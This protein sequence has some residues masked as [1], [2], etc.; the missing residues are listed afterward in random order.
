MVHED[1]REWGVLHLKKSITHDAAD[2]DIFNLEYI[3]YAN[4]VLVLLTDIFSLI[5]MVD[6]GL[7]LIVR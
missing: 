6:L 4:L 1:I 5:S 3:L 7:L 2:Q